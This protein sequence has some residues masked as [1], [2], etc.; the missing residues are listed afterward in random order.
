MIDIK[1]V[2]QSSCHRLHSN[3]WRII[4]MLLKYNIFNNKFRLHY[5]YMDLELSSQS[6]KNLNNVNFF[7]FLCKNDPT[8]GQIHEKLSKLDYL[9]MLNNLLVDNQFE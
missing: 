2:T 7:H 8:K 4:D 6:K 3:F 5:D 9:V 1:A